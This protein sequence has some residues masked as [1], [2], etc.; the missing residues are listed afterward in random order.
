MDKMAILMEK[1]I[2]GTSQLDLA[3]RETNYPV[4]VCNPEP[5]P[6]TAIFR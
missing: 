2:L 3:N 6:S 5:V 4:I 1:L